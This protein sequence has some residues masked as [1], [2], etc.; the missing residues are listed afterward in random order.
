VGRHYSLRSQSTGIRA[1]S[2]HVRCLSFYKK[3]TVRPPP[4]R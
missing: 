2:F 4:L 1:P 3:I